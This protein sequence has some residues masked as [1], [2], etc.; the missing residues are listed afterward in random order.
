M[1]QRALG[2]A[3]VFAGDTTRSAPALAELVD[4]ARAT[5]DDARLAHACYMRS[6]SETRTAGVAAVAGMVHAREAEQAAHRCGNPTALAQA[7]YALGIWTATSDPASS[8]RHLQRSEEIA[9]GVGNT[10]FELFSR[11]ENLWLRG[12]GGDTTG[13]LREFADVVAEWHRAGDWANQWLSLRHVFGLCFL[14]HADELAATIYGALVRAG[15]V[16]AFPVE[17]SA[18]AQLGTMLDELRHRL[19]DDGFLAAEQRARMA[20]TSTVVDLIVSR[21]RDLAD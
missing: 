8:R 6:L 20:P 2:N 11:T 10:W 19:G 1:P 17:P 13:A 15:A 7:D 9:R 18:A 16:D 5:G 21:L 12:L 4:G 14:V 3:Y